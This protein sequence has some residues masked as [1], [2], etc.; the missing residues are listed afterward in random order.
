MKQLGYTLFCRAIL[1]LLLVGFAAN[2]QAQEQAQ[3]TE[4]VLSLSLE[5]A[6]EK[7]RQDS[8]EVNKA[9]ADMEI[10]KADYERGKA[11]YLPRITFSETGIFTNSPLQSFGILLNQEVVE[12]SDF[13]PELLNNPD[14]TTNFNTRLEVQQPIFNMD[15]NYMRKAGA[16][17]VKA[18]EFA[19]QRTEKAIEL[20]VKQ[21]YYQLQLAQESQVVINKAIEA[22][23]ATEELTKRNLEQGYVKDVDLMSIQI[24]LMELENQL[25]DAEGNLQ[26]AQDNLRYLLKLESSQRIEASEELS[27]PQPREA[28]LA[29]PTNRSDFQAMRYGMEAKSHLVEAQRKKFIPRV[30]AFGGFEFNDDIPFGTGA[31]NWG[32][33]I[34]L[35][36][37]IFNGYERIAQTQKARA[38]LDK[39]N[40]EYNQALSQSERD[41]AKAQRDFELASRKLSVTEKSVERSQEE[42]RIRRDR[43]EQ[44]LEKTND[45]LMAEASLAEKELE[46]L[47]TLYQYNMASFYLDFLLEK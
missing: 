21:S 11:S 7:A 43:Y 32:A 30:N 35:E 23:K 38:E 15:A 10:A 31:N 26:N 12:Q 3:N 37:N 41:L 29:V 8:W 22:A 16:A 19:K 47:N 20:Q 14:V 17:G 13:N 9:M 25:A 18:R 6:L 27:R 45:V 44:G 46:Y 28:T 5:E 1:G 40:I 33:G 36:W 42:L 39:A 24:R 4:S 2:L 34:R